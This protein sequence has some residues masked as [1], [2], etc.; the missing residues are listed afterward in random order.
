M[1]SFNTNMNGALTQ[2]IDVKTIFATTGA[3]NSSAFTN[4]SGQNLISGFVQSTDANKRNV[5]LCGYKQQTTDLSSTFEAPKVSSTLTTATQ[6][7]LT[8]D[9][10]C[11][12]YY[13]QYIMV[14]GGGGGGGGG[15]NGG[16]GSGGGSGGYLNSGTTVTNSQYTTATITVGAGGAGGAGGYRTLETY[17]A[18]GSSNGSNQGTGGMGGHY[19]ILNT[20]DFNLGNQGISYG[21][22]GLQG[23]GGGGGSRAYGQPDQSYGGSGGNGGS[24]TVLLFNS[25]SILTAPGGGGGAGGTMNWPQYT[26]NY[27]GKHTGIDRT[28][29]GPITGGQ[30]GSGGNQ[31]N[32]YISSQLCYSNPVYLQTVNQQLQSNINTSQNQ[33]NGGG[34]PYTTY[35]AG[36]NGGYASGAGQS[37][38]N[39][40]SGYASVTIW[41]RY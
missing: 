25:T 35:G 37:G 38:G 30:G 2:N 6:S 13:V 19:F 3:I 36:G 22:Q 9:A 23:G 26:Y 4:Q 41:K 7:S 5:N 27:S 1:S 16:Y 14:G 40:G 29:C 21:N 31:G 28:L 8:L 39:G 12:S 34:S 32:A 10:N 24:S 15:D 11:N 20:S 18:N 33:A 17:G